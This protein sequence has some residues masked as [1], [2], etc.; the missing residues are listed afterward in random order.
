[1]IISRLLN[2]TQ[3]ARKKRLDVEW[4]GNV[5]NIGEEITVYSDNDKN[6]SIEADDDYYVCVNENDYVL[7][8]K[9]TEKSTGN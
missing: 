4:N 2:I 7:V 3:L 9:L 5:A 6:I 8:N 1:M